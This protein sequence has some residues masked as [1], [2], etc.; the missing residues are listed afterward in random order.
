MAA[1]ERAFARTQRAIGALGA[2]EQSIDEATF[3]LASMK[4]AAETRRASLE[5]ADL[6]EAATR[7]SQADTAYRAALAAVSTAERQSLLDYL[8]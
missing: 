1:V 6:V 7:M 4:R 8:R 5:D 2:D 3:R